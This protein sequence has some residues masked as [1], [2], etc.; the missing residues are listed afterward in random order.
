MMSFNSVRTPKSVKIAAGG[1]AMKWII[2]IAVLL[3][4][5]SG[6][7]GAWW[8]DDLDSQH[9]KVMLKGP[10]TLMRALDEYPPTYPWS[11]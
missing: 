4:F 3:W 2:G 8:L 1:M 10:I 6:L 7:I 11:D 5:L 9:W